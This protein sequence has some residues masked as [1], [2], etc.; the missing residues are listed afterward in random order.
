MGTSNYHT[1]RKLRFLPEP[2]ILL[3]SISENGTA[4]HQDRKKY[5]FYINGEIFCFMSHSLADPFNPFP[6]FFI[7]KI[8]TYPSQINLSIIAASRQGGHII[9]GA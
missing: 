7:W 8:S 5:I 1:Q 4:I 2:L 6:S 9:W 3:F